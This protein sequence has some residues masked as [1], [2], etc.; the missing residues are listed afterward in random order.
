[1]LY[2]LTLHSHAVLSVSASNHFFLFHSD[3][4]VKLFVLTCPWTTGAF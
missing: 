4:A 3:S 1:M 2:Y